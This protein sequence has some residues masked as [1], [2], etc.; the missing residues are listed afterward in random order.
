[1]AGQRARG[2]GGSKGLSA[3]SERSGGASRLRRLLRRLELV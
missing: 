2:G 3:T 1:M